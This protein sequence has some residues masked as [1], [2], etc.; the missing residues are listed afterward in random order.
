MIDG[1][2]TE[3]PSQV[4]VFRDVT[5][6]AHTFCKMDILVESEADARDIYYHWLKSTGA[7]DFIEDIVEYET[8]DGVSI[9]YMFSDRPA[10]L[11]LKSLGYHNYNKVLTFLT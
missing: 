5:L 11:K 4:T 3:P 9:R 10:S 1:L 8:E 6:Y 2:L 7:F